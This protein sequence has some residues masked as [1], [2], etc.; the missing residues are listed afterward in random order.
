MSELAEVGASHLPQLFY[1]V[2]PSTPPAPV[3]LEI[4][5]A[6]KAE[7]S[8]TRVISETKGLSTLLTSSTKQI[9]ITVRQL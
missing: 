1:S 2:L 5:T 3:S 7:E 6:K 9:V 8:I 4:G